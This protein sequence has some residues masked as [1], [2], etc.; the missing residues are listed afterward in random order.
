M[1]ARVSVELLST[2]VQTG[3]LDPDTMVRLS[4]KHGNLFALV[5]PEGLPPSVTLSQ[6]VYLAI[7]TQ[8]NCL[9]WHHLGRLHQHHALYD[10]RH[11]DGKSTTL[12]RLLKT[13]RFT[14][15]GIGVE[16]DFDFCDIPY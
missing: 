6:D 4:F 7:D 9:A 10:Y 16:D 15:V 8:T 13:R 3:Q 1:V 11:L 2:A 14:S 5:R 12:D